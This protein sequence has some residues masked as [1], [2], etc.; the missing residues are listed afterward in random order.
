[1]F[2]LLEPGSSYTNHLEYSPL[3]PYLGFTLYIYNHLDFLF[4][5]SWLL[6][7]CLPSPTRMWASQSSCLICVVIHWN[8]SI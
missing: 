8:S 7:S 4:P 1:M 5:I 2:Y 6:V 3:L